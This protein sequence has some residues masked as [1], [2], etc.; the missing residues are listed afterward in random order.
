MNPQPTFCPNRD[1]PSRGKEGA[2]NLRLHDSLRNR[3]KCTACK[4]TFSGNKGTV[5]YNL[6]TDPQL[7]V[8]VVALLAYGCPLQAI[9]ATF[10]LDE[11]TVA[12]WQKRAGQHCQAVHTALVQ[13]PQALGQ[14][15]A[16][17]IRVRCQKRRVVWLAMALCVPTRLWLGGVVSAHRD[18]YLARSLA[19][20]VQACA[21]LG[22][23]LV[24]TDGWS[25]YQEAFVQAFRSPVFTGQRG[26]PPLVRWPHF[27]LCQ[28]LKWQERGRVV[29]I[30]V[31]RL[32]GA[33]TQIVCLLP[34]DQVLNTA[35]LERL[36]ATFRQRLAGLCRRTRC[37][38][39]H[40]ATLSSGVYLVGS[41][42]NFC[43]PH[44]S[45]TK[46]KQPCTPAMAAGV[47]GHLWSVGELLAYQIAPPPYVAPKRRGRP[48]G[49]TARPEQK[50]AK[51]LVTV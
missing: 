41:V 24:V 11:R 2:G 7:V 43:T 39:R 18:K 29:G 8:W 12:A 15:Q 21:R 3:W 33:W 44:Q 1:C 50:R 51:S 10:G 37:L 34:R 25:A 5:F 16:D 35:Y 46:N 13:T 17:E 27:V 26:R 32:R 20:K 31:C 9:V 45:L 38:L 48:P 6:K 47:T 23:L 49:K 36:N 30:R 42:Y 22:A 28:T 40:E 19:Q 4:Q 14:V